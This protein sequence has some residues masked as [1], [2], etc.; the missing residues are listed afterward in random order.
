MDDIVSRLHQ[1]ADLARAAYQP[2]PHGILREAADEIQNL[3]VET[4]KLRETIG[5]MLIELEDVRAASQ[6]AHQQHQPSHDA[7]AEPHQRRR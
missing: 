1:V 3:K 6:S 4:L 7:D 5:E 2:W